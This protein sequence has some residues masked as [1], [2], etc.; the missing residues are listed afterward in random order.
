MTRIDPFK[1]LGLLLMALSAAVA[2]G[3]LLLAVALAG[4]WRHV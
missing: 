1:A 3:V 4:T 2:L